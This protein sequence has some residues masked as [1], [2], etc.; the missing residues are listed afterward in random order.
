MKRIPQQSF[1][2]YLGEAEIISRHER[3]ASLRKGRLICRNVNH[4]DDG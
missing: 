1:L 2:R 4:C 3:Q